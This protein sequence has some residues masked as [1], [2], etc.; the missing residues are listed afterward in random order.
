MGTKISCNVSQI[1]YKGW[2]YVVGSIK[3]LSKQQ[4]IALKVNVKQKSG[5]EVIKSQ[6]FLVVY[7]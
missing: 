5:V 2:D 4:K 6:G 1:I 7:S 3:E